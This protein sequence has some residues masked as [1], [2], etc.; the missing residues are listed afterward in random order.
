VQSGLHRDCALLYCDEV[1]APLPGAAREA[2]FKPA[3]SP[4]LLLAT[5]YIGHAWFATPALLRRASQ[6]P[7]PR[8][9]GVTF[10]LLLRC[11]EQAG[12]AAILAVPRLLCE[13]RP[14]S[15]A[16]DA[17][18]ADGDRR[19]LAAAAAR[20]G[21]DADI[22]PG[23]LAGH[24]RLRR[25]AAV[26]GLVSIIVPTCAAGDLVRA[27]LTTLKART[28][29]RAIEIVAIDNIPPALADT[30][31]WLRD[32]ADT[33]VEIQE[34]FNW[35]RFNNRAVAAARG[36]YLLFL[37]DDIEVIEA[38]WLDA[39]LDQ[40]DRPG[41]GIVG[42]RLLY[43]DGT[44]QHAGMFLA[45]PGLARH[46]FRYAAAD[47]PGYFGLA[48]TPRN[49]M[50][51]T[52]ACL[53][54]RRATFDRLGGFDE[55]HEIINNDLDFCLRVHAA[56]LRTVFTPYA[57]LVHH[58]LAS[59]ATLKDVYDVGRFD[60]RWGARFA[61]G[62]P[63]H[64]PNLTRQSDDQR[65]DDEPTCLV[66]GGH[67]IFRAADIRRILVVKVDHI[68]DFITALPAIRRLKAH[69]PQAHL[70]VLAGQSVRGF[71]GLEPAI[72]A[73]IPF[74]FFHVRSAL[75]K[76]ELEPDALDALR[77]RLAPCGFDLAID[78]RK[79][80]D[81]RELL[82]CAGAPITAG[83]DYMGQYHWLD[84]ALEWEGDRGLHPK[85]YHV[86]DDLLHLVD[87]VATAAQADRTGIQPAAV[88]ALRE[89]AAMPDGLAAFL[90][91]AVV[92]VHAG[93]GN[94]MKQWPE[95]HFAAL[96]DLLIAHHPVQVLLIGGAEEAD[97]AAR[98]LAM[99]GQRDRVLSVVGLLGLRALPAAIAGCVLY[100]GND[101]GPKHIAAALGV[102][103][104]GIHSG[105]VD[106]I[107]WAP[108]GPRAVAVARAMSCGPC[109][110]NR[111]S[112]CPRDLACL[113]QLEPRAVYRAC[114]MLLARV[115]A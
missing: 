75:G 30:K 32:N 82:L 87:A 77:A 81:T 42:A 67:P 107:E 23:H 47:E 95:A 74:D 18:Q 19:A 59:R 24:Y 62:D 55:A 54:T 28:A 79:H 89:E 57:T 71:A 51:V 1:R 64:N 43:P 105:T 70:S 100:V 13:R 48:R 16:D 11:T 3:F 56:G 102:P 96:I 45:A 39:M 25:R 92:C 29:H 52:G 76:R 94:E 34:P 66:F 83:F 112:D 97:I 84:V 14:A 5:N 65:A 93:A 35:S 69:F 26:T 6:A 113:R 38:D 58:E 110:I 20:R 101:S 27:C 80:L 9:G 40:L 108:M 2:F 88:A 60:R 85:R 10:D 111:L 73:F 61:L 15:S 36:E 37:N 104:V 98:V 44:V 53:L 12:A 114:E 72:D 49:V 109:Y 46:A 21:L 106:P 91:G 8:A 7:G 99:V 4:D 90:D 86:A 17:A 63:Y 68:G 115:A 31:A 50:A 22:L 41:V 103:T 78:L 33:V